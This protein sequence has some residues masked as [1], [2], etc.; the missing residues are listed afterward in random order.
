MKFSQDYYENIR[1][2]DETLRLGSSYDLVGRCIKA[3]SKNVKIYFVDGL[4]KDDILVKLI[5]D[6]L[7]V[8]DD[9][10]NTMNSARDFAD[11][12]IPY[13]E[14]DVTDDMD[15]LITFILSG[16]VVYYDSHRA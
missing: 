8:S 13:S 2:L 14:T 5:S 1:R 10:I 4:I 7:A 6:M 9:E 11:R 16:A 3:A 15:E 12:A